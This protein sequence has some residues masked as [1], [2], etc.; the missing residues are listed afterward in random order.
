MCACQIRQGKRRLSSSH[1]DY[2]AS[3]NTEREDGFYES[4]AENEEG[5]YDGG[6]VFYRAGWIP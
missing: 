6:F 1:E 4:S 3:A 5:E 2:Y